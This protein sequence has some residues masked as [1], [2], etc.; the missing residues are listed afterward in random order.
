MKKGIMLVG[1]LLQLFAGKAQKKEFSKYPVYKGNDLGL[2]YTPALSTFKIW[3]PL[4]TAVE[5]ALYDEGEE[6]KELNRLLMSKGKDGVWTAAVKA[7]VKGKFY[8]FR[9]KIK[10]NWS[11]EIPDPYAKAVGVNGKRAMVVDLKETN[12]GDW[13][14]DKSPSFINKTDA[15]IY[16]LHIRDASISPTSGITN[17]GKYLGLTEKGT[18]NKQGLST[19]LD[20]IKELGVTHVHLLPCF[21]F[22]SIDETKPDA[23]YNWGYDPLNYNVPEG[24]YATNAYDGVTRIKEFKQLIK[25]FHE[26]GLRVVMDVVYNH[27]ALTEQSNFN[28]LV[29]GYYYRQTKDGKF[30]NATA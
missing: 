13:A 14:K 2:I 9:V 4:A 1:F 22:N 10:G 27:T 23:K 8:T 21:D 17:K 15:I 5:I 11:D 26:N 25:T 18:K 3:S 6:G 30:S 19:G 29:P 7:N 28:Q 24:S 20:H 16:E 12:P